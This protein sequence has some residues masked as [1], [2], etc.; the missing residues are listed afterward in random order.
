[1]STAGA[2]TPA[3]MKKEYMPSN[4]CTEVLYE[5]KTNKSVQESCLYLILSGE[6]NAV[7]QW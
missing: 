1:M 2:A 7:D 4:V 5:M 6:M 3:D